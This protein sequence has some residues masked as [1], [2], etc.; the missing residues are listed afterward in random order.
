MPALLRRGAAALALIGVAAPAMAATRIELEAGPSDSDGYLTTAVFVEGVFNE[1]RFGNS[2]FSWAPD[3][4]AGYID[5]RN[6]N[7]YG[8]A[9]S[10]NIWLLAGGARLRM[11]GAD[12][13]YHHW[14]WTFQLAAQKG[15]TLALSSAGEFVNSIGWQGDRWTFQLR[16]ISNAGLDG[17][18]RGET[19]AL[20]GWAFDL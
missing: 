5:G 20:V 1:H 8:T 19:M 15:R 14:F 9:V 10:D 18:N 6:V 13:W 16:H 17:S 2:R 11:G 7:R 3:V 12:D 4:S